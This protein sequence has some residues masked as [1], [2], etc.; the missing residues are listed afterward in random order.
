MLTSKA[1]QGEF[2]CNTSVQLSHLQYFMPEKK[3]LP[4]LQMNAAHSGLLV[5][6]ITS[7]WTIFSF[8]P[9]SIFL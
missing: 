7:Y 5:S 1:L 3:K 8:F 4:L 2:I 6:L 9:F